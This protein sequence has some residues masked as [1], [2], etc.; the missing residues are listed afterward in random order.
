[1]NERARVRIVVAAP[2]K[3]GNHWISCLL[4]TI[5]TLQWPTPEA[6]AAVASPETFA[7]FV[8]GGKFPENNLF[9]HHAKFNPRLCDVIEAI[10]AHQVTIVRDP[11]DVFVSLYYW[12]QERSSRGLGQDRPR[13]RHVLAGKPL[14][15]EDVLTFLADAFGRNLARA[16]GWLHSGRAIPVRY[17]ELHSDPIAA[18]CHVTD[19]ID[20]MSADRL[21]AAI[22]ACQA[23]EMRRQD[24]KMQW[25]VRAARV[26]DSR[27]KLSP[28]HLEIFRTRHA[29][30]IRSL[31]Y[32]VR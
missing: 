16:E 18:L 12:E 6:Q 7:A 15:H 10:P 11:Y 5:Y 19:L 14:D 1:M 23:D 21:A 2:P 8:R 27:D 24:E 30:A 4:A 31:G 26:G 13:P 22:A 28:A 9:Y 32:T 20:P 3:S 17:E 29:D 25:H